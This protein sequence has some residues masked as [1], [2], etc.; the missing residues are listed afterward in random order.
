MYI[1]EPTVQKRNPCMKAFMDNGLSNAVSGK[2]MRRSIIGDYFGK[3]GMFNRNARLL[4]ASSLV[5]GLDYGIWQ[6]IFNLYLLQLG[7]DAAFI[8][9][10]LFLGAVTHAIAVFP[11]GIISDRFG[12]KASFL[13]GGAME[14]TLRLVVV[15]TL[16]VPIILS[17]ALALGLP[18]ALVH[19]AWLP[20][21]MEN[22]GPAE[23]TYLFSM[24]AFFEM[25]AMI[26][27]ASLGAGIP[28]F[29]STFLGIEY[30]GAL[31]FRITLAVAVVLSYV[32]LLP[33]YMIK[34]RKEEQVEDIGSFATGFSLKKIQ[35][36]KII[37]MFT[38]TS[39]LI[40]FAGGFTM[41][42]YNI[43][44]NRGLG[45]SSEQIGVIFAISN[46][47]AALGILLAPLITERLGKVKTVFF[48]RVSSLPFLLIM[49]LSPF[50]GIGVAAYLFR[51]FF[52]MMA[53][54]IH[55]TF[56]METVQ[57]RE[58]ATTVGAMHM[59]FDV[60]LAPS[61]IW[62]GIMLAGGN[63]AMPYFIASA[64]IFTSASMYLLFFNKVEKERL[65]KPLKA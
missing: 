1:Q 5:S 11:L 61:S 8:G 27:G 15:T 44:F 17:G 65:A 19:V 12:R 29:L 47:A 20:F 38:I 63:Y 39:G 2:A 6:V 56:S 62:A 51:G 64:A 25:A 32:A 48:T 49:A 28:A 33:L 4:L 23:R 36:G 3:L 18:S 40:G 58:R 41:P 45:A 57:K 14:A 10:F 52:A 46:V 22:S 34:E 60:L 24:N 13:F 55:Q 16:N 9:L 30:P 54:P 42:Y 35:S 37:V 7:F 43:F 53:R 26:V 21:I 50:L 59:A 31:I